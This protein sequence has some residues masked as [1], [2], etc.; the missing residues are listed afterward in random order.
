LQRL[1]PIIYKG[2][3][4]Y[5]V[6]RVLYWPTQTQCAI[7]SDTDVEKYRQR[8]GG[9]IQELSTT[10]VEH[11]KAF[12]DQAVITTEITAFQILNDVGSI[13]PKLMGY[14]LS[15][16]GCRAKFQMLVCSREGSGVIDLTI[17]TALDAKIGEIPYS[18]DSRF[19]P[20]KR[21][22]PGTR[23]AFLDFIFNWVN[24]PA[25]ER[26]LIL[27]GLAGTGK[28]SI[29]H[30]IACRFDEMRRLT[31]SFIFVRNEQ[32]KTNAYQLFTNL[33][34]DLADRYPLFKAALGRS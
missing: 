5:V 12:F 1:Y 16:S 6:F 13:S 15:F 25:S 27:F 26:V 7:S 17:V 3:I 23:M 20:E 28:S 21:C 32:S 24:N 30:E 19:T 29:A 4:L 18:R 31:S 14:P 11:R 33:A 34:R 8:S 10:L 9:K 2:Q 22:L